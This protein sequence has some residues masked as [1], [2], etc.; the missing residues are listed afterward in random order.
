MVPSESDENDS[1]SA[2]DLRTKRDQL[3]DQLNV[4]LNAD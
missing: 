1:P 2:L 3:N 4:M